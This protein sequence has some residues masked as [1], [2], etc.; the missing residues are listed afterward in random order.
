MNYQPRN[1]KHIGCPFDDHQDRYIDEHSKQLHHN[2]QPVGSKLARGE[3]DS[4]DNDSE[5]NIDDE[6]EPNQTVPQSMFV[7]NSIE[8]KNKSIMDKTKNFIKNAE[9]EFKKDTSMMMKTVN[10]LPG[11]ITNDIKDFTNKYFGWKGSRPH[12]GITNWFIPDRLLQYLPKTYPATMTRKIVGSVL[13]DYYRYDV[14]LKSWMRRDGVISGYVTSSNPQEDEWIKKAKTEPRHMENELYPPLEKEDIIMTYIKEFNT[15][16]PSIFNSNPGLD[17]YGQLGEYELL[18]LKEKGLL[19]N[20]NTEK[21]FV[22]YM[23]TEEVKKTKD[24][25]D[26]SDEEQC[27]IS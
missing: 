8:K 21:P 23:P 24:D 5:E 2:S 27:I 13:I 6:I 14:G 9:S 1:R 3:V 26:S 10:E 16:V 18:H 25:G 19:V 17:Q 20:Q 22:T 15:Y 7:K 12:A 11:K 4:E